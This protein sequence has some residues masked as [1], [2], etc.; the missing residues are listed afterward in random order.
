M[1]LLKKKSK[2]VKEDDMED[3]PPAPHD[4]ESKPQRKSS[5]FSIRKKKEDPIDFEDIA[6]PQPEKEKKKKSFL[7]KKK[8]EENDEEDTHDDSNDG[9]HLPPTPQPSKKK[10]SFLFK[11]KSKKEKEE[12]VVDI[13]ME[14]EVQEK[15]KKGFF[16]KQKKEKVEE[17]NEEDEEEKEQKSSFFKLKKKKSSSKLD[18]M[19]AEPLVMPDEEEPI[20]L[21]PP[22][23]SHPHEEVYRS[24]QPIQPSEDEDYNRYDKSPDSHVRA[25]NERTNDRYETYQ[26]DMVVQDEPEPE[27]NNFCGGLVCCY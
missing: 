19:D 9:E 10:K 14:D 1:G 22:P 17:P 7:F 11:S 12:P 26:E 5:K 4:V 2:S 6:P 15:R 27:Q 20:V 18:E 13:D 24:E 25:E 16:T 8:K 21:P 23:A 3:V